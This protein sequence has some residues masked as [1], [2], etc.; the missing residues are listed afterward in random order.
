MAKQEVPTLHGMAFDQIRA[1][2]VNG[3]PIDQVRDLAAAGFTFEQL[4]E[5]SQSP[6]H[7]TGGGFSKEDLKEV[8]LAGAEATRK[9]LKPENPTAPDVSVFNPSGG[10]R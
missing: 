3:L 5:L 7:Q 8:L 6:R 1:L 2:V 4:L 10:P 9:A